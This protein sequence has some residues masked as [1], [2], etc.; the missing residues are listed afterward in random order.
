MVVPYY[1]ENINLIVRLVIDMDIALHFIVRL[2]IDMDIVG[3][4]CFIYLV[5]ECL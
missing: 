5:V 2:D 3:C 4:Y 1:N